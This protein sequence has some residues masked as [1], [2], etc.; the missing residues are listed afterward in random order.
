VADDIAEFVRGKPHI[1]C[2]R[3]IVKPE[4]DLFAAGTNVDMGGLISFI[5]I[6]ESAIRPHRRTVGISLSLSVVALF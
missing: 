4:F 2:H 6:E 1:D 3:E 5:G